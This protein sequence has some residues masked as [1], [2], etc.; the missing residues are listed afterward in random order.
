MSTTKCVLTAACC[1]L[2]LL[3]LDH[4][5][6]F[7][8]AATFSLISCFHSGQ[9]E[10]ARTSFSLAGGLVKSQPSLAAGSIP[11]AKRA[12]RTFYHQDNMGA[13]L[14]FDRRGPGSTGSSLAA[15]DSYDACPTSGVEWLLSSSSSL[16][17][18]GQ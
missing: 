14:R 9:S 3:V 12:L 17:P 18:L 8:C 11:L 1:L 16:L 4:V 2:L 13:D 6:S 10:R 15:A 5:P 7:L